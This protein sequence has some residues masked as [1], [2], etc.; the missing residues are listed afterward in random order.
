MDRED[1]EELG[2]S[3]Q[4]LL[5]SVESSS[6]M[7]DAL[8]YGHVFDAVLATDDAEAMRELLSDDTSGEPGRL[9]AWQALLY[10]IQASAPACL[11]IALSRLGTIP[12]DHFNGS[13]SLLRRA[14][15]VNSST[16]LD[17]LLDHLGPVATS[18]INRKD[19]DGLPLLATAVKL[20]HAKC[21]D[22]LLRW[23]AN[24]NTAAVLL[25]VVTDGE[26]DPCMISKLIEHGVDVNMPCEGYVSLLGA[27][28]SRGSVRIMAS[29][30]D[31]GARIDEVGFSEHSAAYGTPLC[32]A[33]VRASL[34][35]V[36]LL[37]TRGA[38]VTLAGPRGNPLTIAQAEMSANNHT[39]ETYRKII[40]LL[41]N[42]IP[43]RRKPSEPRGS[44]QGASESSPGTSTSEPSEEDPHSTISG[45]SATM[46][47]RFKSERSMAKV[48]SSNLRR[49]DMY[50]GRLERK[51]K[52]LEQRAKAGSA[53]DAEKS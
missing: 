51:V 22:T 15:D 48:R 29:L 34:P 42:A 9:D 18:V 36:E 11:D 33:V 13:G 38:D 46:I 25:A 53:A 1:S 6:C 52:K 19:F 10:S 20:G 3:V 23:G 41:E 16:I 40:H 17:V 24:A 14:V 43:T 21:I 28:A 5:G 39:A 4:N 27:A 2:A 45:V 50:R 30:I 12:I 31:S 35:A 37:I 26:D 44:D 32:T 49:Q 7:R 47:S 8:D